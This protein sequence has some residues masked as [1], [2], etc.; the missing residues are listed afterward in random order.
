[1]C[2]YESDDHVRRRARRH[3]STVNGVWLVGLSP[4]FLLGDNI[5][6]IGGFSYAVVPVLDDKRK[7][8]NPLFFRERGSKR[9][10]TPKCVL[11]MILEIEPRWSFHHGEGVEPRRS[12]ERVVL[13]IV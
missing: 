3:E 8:I 5:A 7:S 6:S 2:V 11:H 10:R 9:E 4:L 1:M 13:R 12:T